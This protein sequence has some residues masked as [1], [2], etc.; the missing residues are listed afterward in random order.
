MK[1]LSISELQCI[2]GGDTVDAFCGGF[3]AV[4]SVYAA[5]VYF[6]FWN[7]VGWTAGAAGVLIGLGCGAYYLV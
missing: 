5:G 1:T 7:P 6:N 2:S 3:A 4:A